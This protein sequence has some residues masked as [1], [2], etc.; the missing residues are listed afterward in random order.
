MTNLFLL[1]LLFLFFA[2]PADAFNEPDNFMGIKFF[3]DLTKTMKQCR[4]KVI[5]GQKMYKMYDSAQGV[6]WVDDG[7][8]YTIHH[9]DLFYIVRA[10][11]VDRKLAYLDCDFHWE[12]Y[13]R[14]AAV[15]RERYGAPTRTQNQILTNGLGAKIQNEV[16]F[17]DGR[18]VSISLRQHSTSLD[19]SQ[20]IYETQLWRD[21][22]ARTTDDWVKKKAKGL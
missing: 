14:T 2:V 21:H 4:E 20:G 1:V 17:W 8:Y 15:F 5:G 9:T 22:S 18:Q 19:R 10:Y 12:L 7:S 13:P 3:S 11:M 16:L 6:C